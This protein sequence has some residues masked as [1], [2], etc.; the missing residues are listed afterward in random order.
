MAKRVISLLLVL[1]VFVSAFSI[2]AEAIEIDILDRDLG[3][4]LPTNS[5]G[6]KVLSSVNLYGDY[7]YINFKYTNEYYDGV[8]Y[9]YEIYSDKDYKNLVTSGYVEGDI[10]NN[11]KCS[12]LIKLKG[13]FKSKTYYAVTYA[14]KE[15]SSTSIGIS[16]D[17]VYKFKI[18]VKRTAAFDDKVVVL[19][20][21]TNTVY[22]PKI[23]WS[24]LSGADKY[25]IYRRS[26]S[27]TKWTRVGSVDGSRRSFTD[28]S[29]K[30]NVQKYIYSVKAINKNGVASR[31]LYNGIY[32]YF[33]RAPKITS[34][35]TIR[36]NAVEIQ[37]EKAKSHR[38]T[39]FRREIGGDW[40]ILHDD[41]GGTKW[42]DKTVENG[43]T[44]RYTVRVGTEGYYISDYIYNNGDAITY[45][46][47]PKL[48][49]LTNTDNAI[50]VSWSAVEGATSY[51]IYRK[52]Y[53][54]SESWQ[55]LAEVDSSVL[56]YT[57]ETADL[58]KSYRYTVR[59]DGAD[60]IGSYNSD[61]LEYVVLGTPT[62]TVSSVSSYHP[63]VTWTSVL[64]AH[65]YEVYRSYENGEWKL[66]HTVKTTSTPQYAT[67]VKSVGT[68]QFKVRALRDDGNVG[69]FS[70]PV[71]T[72]YYPTIDMS[73]VVGED[74]ISLEWDDYA[75]IC[76]SYNLY[77][78][79]ALDE[80]AEY[81]LI[82]NLTENNYVDTNI[83][84]TG[85]YYYQV[86]MVENDIEQD[87]NLQS[88]LSGVS[89]TLTG[90]PKI[91]VED[92]QIFFSKAWKVYGYNF[93]TEAWEQLELDS[94]ENTKAN[95]SK[96]CKDG[97]Y[98][99]GFMFKKNGIISVLEN[100]VVDY[101]WYSTK[102]KYNIELISSDKMKFTI[103]KPTKEIDY[104]EV[105]V[106]KICYKL[107]TDGS[108]SY[109]FID[110]EAFWR[111]KEEYYKV[112]I[113]A[114][115]ENGDISTT[116]GRFYYMKTPKISAI[117]RKSNGDVKL[118]I[119]QYNY[120]EPDWDGYYIYR[121][122]EG[123]TKWTKIKTLKSVPPEGNGYVTKTYTDK[124]AVKGKKYTYL[125]KSYKKYKDETFVSYYVKKSAPTK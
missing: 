35:K 124:T 52:N 72:K 113:Q 40:E 110:D 70:E 1:L 112:T 42:V 34:V 45:L 67:T 96:Y 115:T 31:Y 84:P 78:K 82:A 68:Y 32:C 107:R 93:T 109:S 103:T 9:I 26:V 5:K 7:D 61:G 125:V 81:E 87:V 24:S 51:H 13:N 21:T 43:K 20:S 79:N 37:W 56:E 111:S 116:T 10:G 88:F 44:Y 6:T 117:S 19:K 100:N 102:V 4:L 66:I 41:F 105:Q 58:Q 65:K 122:A 123:E 119:K 99:Y 49:S 29:V 12:A 22:G 89:P 23:V 39:V 59:S 16:P 17:S 114:V 106:G 121:K 101:E 62:V 91:R 50:S 54:S 97:K 118:T 38:Y 95:H 120:G 27:G 90:K 47:S 57:D 36:G 108:K 83:E 94:E 104:Y 98:R 11:I 53:G 48:N 76:D 30:D 60:G 55:K 18:K 8:Y 77:R 86:R 2:S 28:K 46:E 75:V 15:T 14:I 33:V 25:Y 92:D 80:T 71:T 85:L 64:G 63:T 74:N 69:E 3:C 73:G